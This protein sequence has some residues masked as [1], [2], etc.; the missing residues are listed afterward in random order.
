MSAHKL[1]KFTQSLYSKPHLINQV[2]FNAVSAYLNQRNMMK[3]ESLIS[4][5][6][7]EEE[8]PDDLDDFDPEMGIGVINVE[9]ALSYKPVYG[10][11]GEVGMSYTSLLETAEKMIQGGAKTLVLNVDSGG[12]EGYACMES[13]DEL[14]RMCD[15]NGVYLVAYN[16]GMIASAAYAISCAADEIISNPSAD[17]GSIG[18]LVA[19]LNDSKALEQEGYVRSFIYA[20]SKKIPYDAD[21]SWKE[22]FLEDLQSKVDT[23][24]G[25]FVDHVAKYTG[26]DTKII[27]G[28]EAGMFSAQEALSNGLINKIM[29][30]SEFI[31]YLVEKNGANNA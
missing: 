26:L 28:F 24:Y 9:G 16:D 4:D 10:L 2:A 15:E 31:S 7:D 8:T 29:T 11:C 1:I 20:G 21:G 13:A 3:P 30:R 22:S 6:N 27:R 17:T 19:L 5:E 18:V 25:E 12:G 14:R 23:L